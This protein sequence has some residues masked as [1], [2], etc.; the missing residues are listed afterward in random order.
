[1][2]LLRWL[3]IAVAVWPY[4]LF[5][6]PHAI[7]EQQAHLSI[8]RQ[9]AIVSFYIA[10]SG[11]DGAHLFGHVDS[12]GDGKISNSEKHRFSSSLIK[13]SSLVVNGRKAALHQSEVI[14]PDRPM[15]ASGRGTITVKANAAITLG[16]NL[17]NRLSFYVA[18]NRFASRWMIQPH[19]FA[20]VAAVR[21]MVKRIP[22]SNAVEIII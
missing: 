6:H 2:I 21:P 10:P 3:P 8:G 14:F 11:R 12:D 19:Y 9:Q 5:A 13:R 7:V 1:M 4:G 18:Y 15:L 17:R 22:Q 16:K 20:D